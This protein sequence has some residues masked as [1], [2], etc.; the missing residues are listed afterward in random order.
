MTKT[1]KIALLEDN[2]K[3]LERLAEYILKL[4]NVELVIKSR[5]TDDL[6]E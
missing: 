5:T 6:F 3:L 2:T 1:F 4:Q